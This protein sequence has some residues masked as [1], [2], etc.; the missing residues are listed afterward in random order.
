MMGGLLEGLLLAKINQLSD[1]A[2][3]FKTAAAPVDSKTGKKLQLKEWGLKNYIDVAYELLWISRTTKDVGEVMRDYRNY[4]HPQK[5]LS[6]GI[7]LEPGDAKMLW[8][9]AKSIA[10]QLLKR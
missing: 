9:V 6:H 7:V 5:E 10:L 3:V 2:P 4:I 1:K 8:E